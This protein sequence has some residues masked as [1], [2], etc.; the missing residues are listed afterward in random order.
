MHELI[1]ALVHQR[2][3]LEAMF[4]LTIPIH[5]ISVNTQLLSLWSVYS[6]IKYGVLTYNLYICYSLKKEDFSFCSKMLITRQFL[7]LNRRGLYSHQLRKEGSMKTLKG[8]HWLHRSIRIT[9]SFLVLPDNH[10]LPL[11]CHR[12]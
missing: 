11:S 8:F 3:H 4:R 9:W 12:H 6:D 5:K 10:L 7:P 1:L 2:M